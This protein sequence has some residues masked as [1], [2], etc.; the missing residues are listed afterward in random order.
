ML[1]MLR[2]LGVRN[3]DETSWGGIT[4]LVVLATT[5]KTGAQ[6]HQQATAGYY[7]ILLLEVVLL[8]VLVGVVVLLASAYSCCH[9]APF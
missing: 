5:G 2:G 1:I 6:I 9:H 7:Y 8:V 4:I 3:G